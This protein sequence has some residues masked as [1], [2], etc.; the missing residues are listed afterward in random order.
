MTGMRDQEVMYCYWSDVNLAA[1]AVRVSYKPDLGW[2]PKAYKEREIPIPAKLVAEL[3]TWK[4]KSDN[5][6]QAGVSNL[7]LQV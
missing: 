7:R 5:D 2:T 4:A 1:A 6:L 3:K